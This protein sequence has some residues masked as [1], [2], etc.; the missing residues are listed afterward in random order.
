VFTI[1]G[2]SDVE[3]IL[4]LKVFDRWGALVFESS[5][6]QPNDLTIG[7][8]GKRKGKAEA[9]GVFIYKANISFIGG[10]ER[11]FIGSVTLVK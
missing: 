8:D 1:F 4:N 6:L 9:P 2:G 5:N 7:W 10:R 11:E 3:E